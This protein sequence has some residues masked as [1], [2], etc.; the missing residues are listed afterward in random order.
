M[1]NTVTEISSAQPYIGPEN[2][3]QRMSL[4]QFDEAI[5]RDGYTYELNKGVIEVTNIPHRRHLAQVLLIRNQLI[6]YQLSHP[7]IIH[8]VT[9]SHD[10]KVLIEPEQSERHPDI[11][12]Y[13]SP[14][15]DVDDIWSIWV[16]TI[17]VEVVSD[18]SAKRDYDEKPAEYLAFGIQ[19]YWI[20]DR[21]KD[22]MTVLSR[23]RSKWR[24]QVLGPAERY[25]TPHLPGFVLELKP[26]LGE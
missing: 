17:A 5:G 26:I 2:N 23:Y 14:M 4:A 12:V 11:A 10:S 20:V 21:F 16:P 18:S 1:S 3:G 8:A 6:G 7:E 24:E 19:E 13:L 9:G 25:S 22:R 15:P